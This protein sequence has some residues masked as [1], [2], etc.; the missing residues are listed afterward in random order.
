MKIK[1]SN[2]FSNAEKIALAN[3]LLESDSKK[4]TTISEEIQKELENRLQLLEEGKTE[5]YTWDE[6]KNHLVKI[7]D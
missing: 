1:D 2:N 3:Q 6:V 7:R 4:D 5:Y